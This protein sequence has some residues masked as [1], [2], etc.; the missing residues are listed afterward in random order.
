M[1]GSVLLFWRL[2]GHIS[3][4]LNDGAK[5]LHC[6]GLAKAVPTKEGLLGKEGMRVYLQMNTSFFLNQDQIISYLSET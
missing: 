1:T 3:A 5:G 2:Q 4:P 6:R